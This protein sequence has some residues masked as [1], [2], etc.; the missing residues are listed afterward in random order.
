ME[1]YR[2]VEEISWI[3]HPT[4]QGVKIKPLISEK[5]HGLNVKGDV[6]SKTTYVFGKGALPCRNWLTFL[7]AVNERHSKK[8]YSMPA[9]TKR[10]VLWRGTFVQ[11]FLNLPWGKI[12]N[13][14][15]SPLHQQLKNQLMFWLPCVYWN[16]YRSEYMARYQN[17]NIFKTD[18]SEKRRFLFIVQ[19]VISYS[20]ESHKTDWFLE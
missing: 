11:K 1:A 2:S 13:L 12:E 20:L 7:E 16:L 4:A 10:W 17:S 3:S 5:E 14:I 15:P 18:S 19:I 6:G 9:F 8:S